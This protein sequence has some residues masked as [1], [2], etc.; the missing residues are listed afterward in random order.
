VALLSTLPLGDR[1][2]SSD[3]P[4]GVKASV[5]PWLGSVSPR[6]A[7]QVDTLPI[8]EAQFLFPHSKRLRTSRGQ[9]P[10]LRGF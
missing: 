10:G 7:Y 2:A 4:W 1:D 8:I 5:L 3:K 6:D 9:Y